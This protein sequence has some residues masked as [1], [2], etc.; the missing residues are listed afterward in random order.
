[1]LYHAWCCDVIVL[2]PT[3]GNAIEFVNL[4]VIKMGTN[5]KSKVRPKLPYAFHRLYILNCYVRPRKWAVYTSSFVVTPAG[6]T[7]Y[8]SH[9]IIHMLLAT[10]S[11]LGSSTYI[12]C[13]FIGITNLAV[14]LLTVIFVIKKLCRTSTNG[15]VWLA[16][17]NGLAGFPFTR[18][19]QV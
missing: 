1:M 11:L 5:V 6:V 2:P 12:K 13:Y 10:H 4:T 8:H 16:T 19:V 18:L 17:I 15:N 7:C 9:V 14:L 3:H